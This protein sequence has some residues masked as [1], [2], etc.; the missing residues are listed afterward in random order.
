MKVLERLQTQSVAHKSELIPYFTVLIYG[1]RLRHHVSRKLSLLGV[2]AL[3]K[4]T[5]EKITEIT[6]KAKPEEN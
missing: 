6:G 1:D 3:L 5:V 2:L 4:A